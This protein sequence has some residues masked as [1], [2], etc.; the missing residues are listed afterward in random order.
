VEVVQMG[1]MKHLSAFLSLLS[2]PCRLSYLPLLHDILHS[3]NP[4]N[5]RL[6]QSLAVQVS[7]LEAYG[8]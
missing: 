2:Q 8:H 6:R 1:V 4:F 7:L 5:W 3:T